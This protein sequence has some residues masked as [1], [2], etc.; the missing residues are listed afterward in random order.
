MAVEPSGSGLPGYRGFEYQIDA[1]IWISLTALLRDRQATEIHIEPDSAEDIEIHWEPDEQSATLTL[2]ASANRRVI[3]QCKTRSTGPWTQ[4]ALSKVIG[5][6][7]SRPRGSRGPAPRKRA[8]EVLLAESEAYYYLLTNAGVDSALFGLH[9]DA[10]HIPPQ[11]AGSAAA[12]LDPSLRDGASRLKGRV[13]IIAGLTD[14]LLTFRIEKLLFSQFKIPYLQIHRCIAALKHACR[15]RLLGH[16]PSALTVASLAEL[17]MAHG[18][19][20]DDPAPRK[21]QLP[22][23]FAQMREHLQQHNVILLLGPPGVGKTTLAE[24]LAALHRSELA[25]FEVHHEREISSLSQK[26]EQ[27]GPALFVI[28]DPWGISDQLSTTPLTHEM[29]NFLVRANQDK[30]FVITSRSDIYRSADKATQAFLESYVYRVSVKSYSEASLWTIATQPI[31]TFPAALQAAKRSRRDILDS[32]KTPYELNMFG[33]LLRKAAA[34]YEIRVVHGN[35]PFEDQIT[36]TWHTTTGYTAESFMI[37]SI[38]S[39]AGNMITAAGIQQLLKRWPINP[40]HHAAV[41]W[42]LLEAFE[43]YECDAF[44]Q[45]HQVIG[46]ENKTE[47]DPTGFIEY[48][49]EEEILDVEEGRLTAHSFALRGMADYVKAHANEVGTLLGRL[50]CSFIGKI[51]WDSTTN[52]SA[53]RALHLVDVWTRLV[54]RD[55]EAVVS[56]IE[57]VDAVLEARCR[58]TNGHRFADAASLAIWW[59]YGRTPFARLMHAFIPGESDITPPWYPVNFD[60]ETVRQIIVTGTAAQWLP[61]LIAEFVPYT[62]IWY[63]YEETDFVAFITQFKVP[64]EQ[65]CRAALCT[66]D[67]RMYVDRGDGV[68]EEPN[69]DVNLKVLKAL[70]ATYSPIPYPE[71]PVR[72]K[73]D[74]DD[75]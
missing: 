19:I 56:V 68:C 42:L 72:S 20:T 18:G 75:Y 65:A 36:A 73:Y 39:E 47:L 3:I 12:F 51:S 38:I 32:L 35:P 63:G 34:Q 26:L 28:S 25:P 52:D 6:G 53:W 23:D 71:R 48:L 66:I 8:L 4:D 21:L 16:A 62:A 69:L 43:S 5:N 9:Q 2:P 13:A 70:L 37:R 15:S 55:E 17:I 14:E 29:R 61:R 1:S 58:A 46:T 31:D 44:V 67:D 10:L 60:A 54:G 41:C 49:Q 45:I 27:P 11:H 33:V 57:K 64:L 50:A 40:A 24:H 30:R 74:E 59:P 7:L 22:I